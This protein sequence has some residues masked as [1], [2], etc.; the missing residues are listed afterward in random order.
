M[1]VATTGL[2]AL[3]AGLGRRL[4]QATSEVKSNRRLAIGLAA[5]G[6]LVW[7]AV[8]VA[9]GDQGTRLEAELRGIQAEADRLA[10]VGRERDWPQRLAEVERVRQTLESRLWQNTSESVA[11]VDFQD[12]VS[13]VAR[14]AGLERPDI[15]P[16][17][18]TSV[19]AIPGMVQFNVTLSA[20]FTPESFHQ[21]LAQTAVAP[22]LVV[23]Q[24]V[25]VE[26]EPLR[27][28]TFLLSAYFPGRASAGG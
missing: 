24:S 22:K 11:R 17:A 16:E 27:R 12:W 28:V 25:R 18:S 2:P 15:R 21:F 6:L 13:R 5:L 19:P 23:V 10:R 1:K 8:V 20:A 14:E 4:A 9:L 26:R 7:Y 3:T